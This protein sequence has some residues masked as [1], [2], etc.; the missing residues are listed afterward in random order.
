MDAEVRTRPARA[1]EIDLLRGITLCWVIF[2]HFTYDMRYIFKVNAFDYLDGKAYW[3]FWEPLVLCVFVGLAGICCSFSRNNLKRGIKLAVVAAI[4]T[5]VTYLADRYM[6]LGCLILF[7]VIHVLAVS[8][9]I[10]TLISF[11]ERR[12][13]IDERKVDLLLFFIAVWVMTIGP[14]LFRF[15]GIFENNILLPIGIYGKTYPDMG[16]YMPLIP[17]FGVFL[18]GAVVGRVLYKDKKTLFPD[19]PEAL[20]K[21]SKPFE[22]IGRHSL[23]IYIVHQPLII[24]AAY[25]IFFV[26]R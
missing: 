20:H 5:L 13:G 1:F 23:I 8:I 14:Q 17:W 18:A 6:K 10:Y 9:L 11:V 15:N 7:N 24:G 3:T 16:D 25:L 21:I 19:A 12:F 26:G 4:L 22:F 2:M